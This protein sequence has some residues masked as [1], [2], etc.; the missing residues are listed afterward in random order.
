MLWLD[1]EGQEIG[2][3]THTDIVVGNSEVSETTVVTTLTFTNLN[4]SHS[5][6]YTCM[7]TLAV[8]GQHHLSP[9]IDEYNLVVTSKFQPCTCIIMHNNY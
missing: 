3:D 6:F 1:P 2:K 7:A 8:P 9:I 4:T 5:G